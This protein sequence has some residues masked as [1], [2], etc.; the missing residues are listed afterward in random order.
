MRENQRVVEVERVHNLVVK[1]LLKKR[2]PLDAVVVYSAVNDVIL[3]RDFPDFP[4]NALCDFIPR[5]GKFIIGDF[6][7]DFISDVVR[8]VGVTRGNR[9]PYTKVSE[10]ITF[11]SKEEKNTEK[12]GETK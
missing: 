9:F 6:V 1:R 8:F 7:Q 11:L 10:F 3:R 4:D 12:M 5:L 2:K